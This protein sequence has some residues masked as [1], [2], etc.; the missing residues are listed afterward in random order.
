M[1]NV[2]MCVIAF[3]DC[4]IHRTRKGVHVLFSCQLIVN[5]IADNIV[6]RVL[7]TIVELLTVVDL[8]LIMI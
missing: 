1:F 2:F 8:S 4:N 6:L 3:I 7:R 5:M